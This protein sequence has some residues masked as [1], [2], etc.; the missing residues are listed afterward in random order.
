MG[1]AVA[2]LVGVAV[3]VRVA[4]GVAVRVAVGEGV[5]EAAARQAYFTRTRPSLPNSAQARCTVPFGA[6]PTATS[7]ISPDTGTVSVAPQAPAA[8]RRYA[9][10]PACAQAR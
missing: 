7:T 5:G 4:V 8:Q 9:T 6:A 3:G 10:A 2:V 1:V